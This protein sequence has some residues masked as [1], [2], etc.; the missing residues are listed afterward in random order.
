MV[1]KGSPLH[2]KVGI[3]YVFAMAIVAA[4]ALLLSIENLYTNRITMG[5]FLGFLSLLTARPLLLG[6]MSLSCKMERKEIYRQFHLITSAVIVISGLGLIYY[7]ITT[8][9]S[10]SPVIVLFGIIGFIAIPE[11]I[12]ML[13]TPYHTKNKKWLSDH[14]AFMCISGIAA[15]T[16][17]LVFGGQSIL[18]DY[19]HTLVSIALWISPTVIG[20]C[21]IHWAKTKHAPRH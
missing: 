13:K 17:F 1:V 5:L 15:H 21:L 12:F 20:L 4:T 18:P 10:L 2:K 8:Q 6:L 7:G 9:H 19:Q 16:A 11:V 3:C 14:I